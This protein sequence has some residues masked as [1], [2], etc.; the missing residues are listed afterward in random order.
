MQVLHTTEIKQLEETVQLS[1][2]QVGVSE[3][4]TSTT[5]QAG[6]ES[7]TGTG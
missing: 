6:R 4:T 5:L 3:T 7:A 2:Q 1:E